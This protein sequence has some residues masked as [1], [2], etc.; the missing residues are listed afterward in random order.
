MLSS[1]STA[2]HTGLPSYGCNVLAL[3]FCLGSLVSCSPWLQALV[4]GH[5]EPCTPQC[6]HFEFLKSLRTERFRPQRSD[7]IT[8]HLLGLLDS[9]CSGAG[10]DCRHPQFFAQCCFG[11]ILTY[12]QV[13][14][15]STN[16]KQASHRAICSGCQCRFLFVT[17]KGGG[18]QLHRPPVCACIWD[19]A[20]CSTNATPNFARPRYHFSFLRPG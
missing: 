15:G 13:I 19:V 20:I 7:C 6:F 10:V 8:L 4:G 5:G 14:S 12:R 17:M 11:R 9:C 1:C 18:W 16:Q 2:R 3:R